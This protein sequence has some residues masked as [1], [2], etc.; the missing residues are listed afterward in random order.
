MAGRGGADERP[1]LQRVIPIRPMPAAALEP[2]QPLVRGDA[3]QVQRL[4][5]ALES[6]VDRALG[7]PLTAWLRELQLS[8]GEALV[9]VAPGLGRD[10]VESAAIA[11]DT[12][13]RLLPDTD[14][15]VGVARD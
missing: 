15:Y 11:F 1:G 6:D 2:R 7:L 13:R 9:A 14:I 5:S 8:D 12:L 10:G 3:D 4:R